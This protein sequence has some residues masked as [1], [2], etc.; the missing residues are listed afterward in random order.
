MKNTFRAGWI[1]AVMC[2]NRVISQKENVELTIDNMV[3][4]LRIYLNNT[5]N[6]SSSR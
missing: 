4:N 3:Y 1:M 2:Y 5:L 6:V